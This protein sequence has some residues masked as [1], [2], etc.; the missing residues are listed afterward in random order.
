MFLKH[1]V[2]HQPEPESS[3]PRV[4]MERGRY[5][6]GIEPVTGLRLEGGMVDDN[7]QPILQMKILRPLLTQ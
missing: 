7:P 2:I 5:V 1:E 6:L 4:Q 3:E